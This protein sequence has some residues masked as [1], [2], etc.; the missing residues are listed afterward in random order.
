MRY[1]LI[2]KNDNTF[3]TVYSSKCVT[4]IQKN[5]ETFATVYS[6]KCVTVFLN[7]TIVWIEIQTDILPRKL[8][9]YLMHQ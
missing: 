3:A 8:Y 2:Q 6:S 9:D 1:S 5:D 7:Q 4:L